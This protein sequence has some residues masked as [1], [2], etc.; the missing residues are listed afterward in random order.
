MKKNN[1]LILLAVL[2]VSVAFLYG[3]TFAS[4]GIVNNEIQALMQDAL[5]GVGY[6]SM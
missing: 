1:E 5:S 2:V 3:F 6:V 4:F